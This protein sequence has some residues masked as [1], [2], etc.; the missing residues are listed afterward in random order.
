M[1]LKSTAAVAVM[2]SA[3][4]AFTI[5]RTI[6]APVDCD[7]LKNSNVP[8][9]IEWNSTIGHITV[10]S[11][12]D[13]SGDSIEWR[14]YEYNG[15]RK[16]ITKVVRYD[17]KGYDSNSIDSSPNAV[18]RKT[19]AITKGMPARYDY[20]RDLKYTSEPTSFQPD[21]TQ[22]TKTFENDVH[23]L[24]NIRIVTGSCF[25]D[26]SLAEVSSKQ[27]DGNM[28]KPNLVM[29]IKGLRILAFPVF[30]ESDFTVKN[31]FVPL[32]DAMQ[33]MGFKPF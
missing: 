14:F 21:G 8:F 3:L 23:F 24:K 29:Y 26:A 12:R 22:S 1:F 32:Q 19:K 16:E 7:T 18:V 2:T 15:G 11:Y 33:M 25:F 30:E 17:A 13:A 10:Q 5:D 31:D 27:P 6:A 4:F 20:S 28:S 9:Q